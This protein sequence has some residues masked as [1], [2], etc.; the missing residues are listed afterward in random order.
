M[1]SRQSNAPAIAAAKA[2]F[3]TASA[4]RIEADPRLPSQKKTPRG[5]RRPDPL[6]AVWD[7]E[8]VPMLEAAPDLRAGA[9]F[10]EICRRRRELSTGVRRTL[11]RR[12]ANWG[13]TTARTAM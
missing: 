8:I 4:Y 10:E 13:R 11:E 5:R 9:I 3:S 7:S 1:K 2:G 6:S 12:I